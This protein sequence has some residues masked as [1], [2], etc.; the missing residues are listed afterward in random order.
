MVNLSWVKTEH[1]EQFANGFAAKVSSLFCK[2]TDIPQSLPAQGG[3]AETVN[4]HTV[5]ENVP[6]GAKFTD[7]V[8]G[9]M[10]GATA[11][12]DGESGLVPTP[13][14]GKNNSFLRGDGV[15]EEITEATDVDIDA[16]VA[17]T[18]E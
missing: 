17:G 7:T 12:E 18:F 14:K 4:G 10:Q 13:Q 2:K 15:W 8:Y 1:L 11:S 5:F 16:I 6:S 3:D 9:I